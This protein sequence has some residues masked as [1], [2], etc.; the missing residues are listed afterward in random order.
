MNKPEIPSCEKERL[1]ALY[2]MSILDTPKEATFDAVTKLA[3]HFF[4]V[5]I[6]A[7]SLVDAERQWFKSIQG[8][9]VCETGRD[10]SFCGH[11][12]LQDEIMVIEDATQDERFHDNP[13]VTEE[14]KIRYYAGCPLKSPTGNRLGTL[15]IIDTKPRHIP[16]E[17]LRCLKDLVLLIEKE[18]FEK[19]KSAAYLG[20]IAKMQEMHISGASRGQ[21]FESILGFLIEHTLSEYGFIASVLKDKES[22]PYLEDCCMQIQQSA[23]G[24]DANFNALKDKLT[25]VWH[26]GELV[27]NKKSGDSD[28]ISYIGVPIHSNDGVIAIYGLANRSGG[29]DSAMIADLLMVTQLIG[30]I[31]ESSKNIRLMESMSKRDALTGT[32]N[33]LYLKNYVK[34]L[35]K[36]KKD[37][38]K[39]CLL[40][41]DLDDFKRVNDYHGH[42]VGDKLLL[43]FVSRVKNC[44]KKFDFIARIGGDEFVVVLDNIK[45]YSDAGSVAERIIDGASVSYAINGQSVK[46]TVSVGVVSYPISGSTYDELM[47]H[48]DLALYESKKKKNTLTF[49]SDKLDRRFKKRL[50]L[51]ELIRQAFREKEFYCYYQPQVDRR[52]NEIVG[53]EALLRWRGKEDMSPTEFVPV[54][55]TMGL[56]E[57]LNQYVLDTVLAD[58]QEVRPSKNPLKVAVNIAFSI[59]NF[60]REITSLL[61]QIKK[62]PLNPLISLEFEVTESSVIRTD[63]LQYSELDRITEMLNEADITLAIDDFGIKYSSIN[64]LIDYNFDTIKIDKSFIDRLEGDQSRVAHA[65][66]NAV[67][68]LSAELGLRAIAEGVENENQCEILQGCSCHVMQG[69]YFYK[70]LPLDEIVKLV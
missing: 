54:I 12:I 55:E 20:E 44:L 64:R 35:V 33:R 32:Y 16:I 1:K 65:I 68:G 30:S 27:V 26:E 39:F 69:F 58:M 40:M 52:G 62:N 41:I 7:I 70:P 67:S 51:E 42:P 22:A 17:K 6:V 53:I 14:P 13:L 48:V 24:Q 63:D 57:E 10:V 36:E 5:P 15:C 50:R 37:G 28:L 61:Q 8:L 66:V 4:D 38:D 9:D 47:R 59:D 18:F 46:S 60:K 34:Q 31:V 56:A 21:L 19:R 11:T 3:K 29:Y 49:Y 43:D 25:S 23:K 45:N 2:S